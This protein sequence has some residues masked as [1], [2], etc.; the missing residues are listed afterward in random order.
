MREL[1]LLDELEEL[2][3]KIPWQTY[4]TISGQIRKGDMKGAAVGIE[5]LKKRISKEDMDNA[6]SSR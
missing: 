6:D 5:R 3:G 2:K 1:E 4:S